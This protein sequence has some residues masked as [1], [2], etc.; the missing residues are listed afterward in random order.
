MRTLIKDLLSLSRVGRNRVFTYVDCAKTLQE[1]LWQMNQN[2]QE[3]EAQIHAG[4]LP[5]VYASESELR[6]LFQNLISN[7][8]KFRKRGVTPIITINAEEREDEFIFS[9]ADNGIGIE[10]KYLTRVFIIFQRL[11]TPDEYPGTGIGLATCKKIVDGHNGKI[12]I[13]STPE[14]GSTFYFSLPKENKT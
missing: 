11:H 10:E 14:F 3:S 5:T 6:Q 7:A 4:L 13:E 12:W 1:V 2:I 8:V 9:V